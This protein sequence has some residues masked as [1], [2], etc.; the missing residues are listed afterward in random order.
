MSSKR[1]EGPATPNSPRSFAQVLLVVFPE[2]LLAVALAGA[3]LRP[4]EVAPL[5][6]GSAEIPEPT[7]VRWGMLG[8]G[9][10]Y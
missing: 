8:R 10:I 6:T 2:A 9:G 7:A 3:P 4:P 5:A 1:R